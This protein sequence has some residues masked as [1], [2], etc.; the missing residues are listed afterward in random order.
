MN[1]IEKGA[2]WS[3][4]LP[5]S[6]SEIR[7]MAVNLLP[8]SAALAIIAGKLRQPAHGCFTINHSTQTE[9]PHERRFEQ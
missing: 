2:I 3:T 9:E 8:L 7:S 5:G 6:K 1:A 4:I